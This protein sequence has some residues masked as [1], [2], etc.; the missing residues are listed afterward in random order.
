[1]VVV[2]R[3]AVRSI[4]GLGVGVK[5]EDIFSEWS[6]GSWYQYLHPARF[7]RKDSARVGLT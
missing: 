1:M 3:V 7:E 2:V 5:V 6:V 4:V